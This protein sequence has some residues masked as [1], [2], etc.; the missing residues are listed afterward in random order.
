M[1]GSGI[2]LRWA[3]N[4]E[5]DV[6]K[7]VLYR[8]G[9]IDFTPDAGHR[10]AIIEG[11]LEHSDPEWYPGSSYCYKLRAKDRAG[12][13]GPC[14]ATMPDQYVATLLQSFSSALKGSA[15]EITWT[16]AKLD[17]GARFAVYR[18][19]ASGGEFTPVAAANI[20]RS[21]SSFTF[22]DDG[23]AGG[24]T[25]SYRVTYSL[26]GAE[27][28]LFETDAIKTPEL[29]LALYQNFPNP[30]NP[31]TTIKYYL[32]SQELV[33]LAVFDASGKLVVT[34]VDRMQEKGSH[35]VDWKGV[36]AS[37]AQV[38]SGVYFYRL[39]AGAKTLTQ[40]MVLVR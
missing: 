21:G 24:E 36:N 7:Y 3:A 13:E 10:L 32:P 30:F 8:G 19:N 20:V 15:V 9:V 27:H 39:A 16:L 31:T 1:D 29:P 37:G 38:R 14:A 2:M 25:Y 35:S 6:A 28:I 22:V 4:P 11:A 23:I 17:E 33:R 5:P 12:N 34:L 18:S 26:A 40:K